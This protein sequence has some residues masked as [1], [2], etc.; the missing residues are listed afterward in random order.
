MKGG[1]FTKSEQII[2][3]KKR[4][5]LLLAAGMLLSLCA[6]GAQPTENSDTKE[7]IES[8]GIE[9]SAPAPA[10]ASAD[11]KAES[12]E[13][14][15]SGQDGSASGENAG[16]FGAA[17]Q[18]DPAGEVVITDMIGREVTIVPGS[19]KRVVCIGAG[20]LRMYCYVGDTA[21]LC[22]VEDIDNTSL[23]ER[24]KMFDGVA[25]PYVLAFGDVFA[26][27]DS[28]GVGGPNA[29]AAEAEKILSCNPDIVISEYEDVEKEDALQEQLGVPVITLRSGADGVFDSAFGQTMTMLGEIFSA[30][31]KAETL[32]S[33]IEAER[34]EIERRTASI[35]EEEKPGVYICGL[36]NW[37]TTN[38]LMTAQK[39]ISFTVANI[40]N[41][42]EGL[43]SDGIQP[44]E[45]EKFVSW[46]EDMDIMI[47]DAAAMKNIRPLYAEDSAM[48]DSCK[49]WREGEVYLQMAYNAYYT[50]YETALINTWYLAKT[51]YPEAFEDINMTAKT[52]EITK[53]FLG[54]ELAEEIFACPNSFGGYQRIDTGSFFE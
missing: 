4:T 47:I 40:R 11:G 46:G 38:H 5:A 30:E 24:P 7:R 50:N 25:R 23:E 22:G 2:R 6:C 1:S 34:A 51:V 41:V 8:T 20:A 12:A 37:G 32:V 15:A 36:G 16:G 9:D 21:L 35:A 3:R 33:F 27:L 43:A 53:A 10:G 52:N 45:E 49:A 42:A 26:D 28:C 14:T 29:Q 44:V 19:Y 18:A 54:R 39:Y 48:F 31:E 17:G 13:G